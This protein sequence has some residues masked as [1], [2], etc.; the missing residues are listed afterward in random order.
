ML[1]LIKFTGP[2]VAW[3]TAGYL[4]YDRL[5]RGRP[6]LSLTARNEPVRG[7]RFLT[8]TNLGDVDIVILEV[9]FQPTVYAV[10][11]GT[12]AEDLA[13]A[14]T[15]DKLRCLIAPHGTVKL[16]L[17]IRDAALEAEIKSPVRV[18][19]RWRKARSMGVP[20]VPAGI[21]TSTNAV[22]ELTSSAE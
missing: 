2:I 14:I 7:A 15:G 22:R 4:I 8:I 9:I 16:H 5:V 21:W 17:F 3:V 20:Q 18:I 1:E 6:L 13:R 12:R 19:V 11:K 10:S